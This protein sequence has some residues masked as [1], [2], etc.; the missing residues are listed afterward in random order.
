[1]AAALRKVPGVFLSD[2]YQHSLRAYTYLHDRTAPLPTGLIQGV[3]AAAGADRLAVHQSYR[4]T[5]VLAREADKGTGLRAL[6]ELAGQEQVET[7]A[8]GDSEPDLPMFCAAQRSYAP[9]HIAGRGVARLL[10]CTI[11]SR[12]YQLGLLAAVEAIVHGAEA[13]CTRCVPALPDGAQGLFW[14]LLVAADQSALRSM[15]RA[16]TDP[17]ALRAFLR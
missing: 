12:S 17:A 16:C 3:L 9:R 6:L 1:V 4:D 5:A 11:A 15:A 10:G 2:R 7:I 13:R 8:I 14:S